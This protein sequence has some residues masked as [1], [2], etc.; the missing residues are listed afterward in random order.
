MI[1]YVTL[2][3]Y[4][5]NSVGGPRHNP[6]PP[7]VRVGVAVAGRHGASARI[8]K[9]LR[10]KAGRLLDIP[11]NGILRHSKTIFCGSSVVAAMS[12]SSQATSVAARRDEVCDEN[13]D[14][15]LCNV[16]FLGN[17]SVLGNRFVTGF[18]FGEEVIHRRFVVRLHVGG[19]FYLFYLL[20]LQRQ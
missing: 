18:V 1:A 17:G 9:T 3:T 11:S 5:I 6:H 2:I 7:F 15:S 13:N 16:R 8:V 20:L 12:V 19:L 10:Q 4:R 14:G